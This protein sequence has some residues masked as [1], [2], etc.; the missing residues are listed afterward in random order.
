MST[1]D[2]ILSNFIN[3]QVDVGLY[4]LDYS[5]AIQLAIAMDRIDLGIKQELKLV[6]CRHRHRNK[7]TQA[8]LDKLELSLLPCKYQ[9]WLNKR[10]IPSSDA[11]SLNYD[12]LS[13]QDLLDLYVFPSDYILDQ[14][15]YH[16]IEGPV[17]L[18]RRNGK[19]V[20]ICVRNI[21]TDLNYAA[22]EKYTI[23]NYGFYLYGYDLY[24]PDDEIYLV[25][26]VFDAIVMRKHGYK[27]IALAS[28]SPSC[29]QLACLMKKY[30]NIRLCLDNDF[31]GVVNAYIVSKILGFPIYL[32]DLKDPGCYHD[33]PISLSQVPLWKIG[34][35]VKNSINDYNNSDKHTRPLPYN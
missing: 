2:T 9:E 13:L 18:D 22:A 8:L 33:L 30:R 34:R 31:W 3:E 21:T 20:G 7:Q 29:I 6:K 19:L 28:C 12:I 23:S 5:F 24:S 17:F 26:G 15:G 25:E 10:G 32:T 27:S 16:P 35:R 14:F 4:D 11:Y 1:N